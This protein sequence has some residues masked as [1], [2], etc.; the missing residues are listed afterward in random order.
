MAKLYRHDPSFESGEV[1]PSLPALCG[2]PVSL[3]AMARRKP[4]FREF[5]LEK[6]YDIYKKL[7]KDPEFRS[8]VR[9]FTAFVLAMGALEGASYLY[10]YVQTGGCDPFT[11]QVCA[12]VWRMPY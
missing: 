5:L 12:P 2:D 1:V 6:D 9:A 8:R 4:T 7:C 10:D 11:V 3:P